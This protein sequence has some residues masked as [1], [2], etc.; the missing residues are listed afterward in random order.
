MRKFIL[1]FLV[2]FLFSCKTWEGIK[3]DS[4]DIGESVGK[5]A[6]TAGKNIKKAMEEE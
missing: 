2:M 3:E 5:A 1:F 6:E 4:R